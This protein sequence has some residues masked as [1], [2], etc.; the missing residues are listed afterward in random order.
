MITVP[1]FRLGTIFRFFF[2]YALG[3]S[4]TRDAIGAVAP[5][6]AVV[7]LIGLA[8]EIR[9]VWRW[10]PSSSPPRASF[11][12]AR[13]FAIFW[14]CVVG[15]AIFAYFAHAFLLAAVPWTREALG[16]DGSLVSAE[17][18]QTYVMCI[19]VVLCNSIERWRPKTQNISWGLERRSRWLILLAL[20]LT[21]IVL[22]N[23]TLTMFVT[24]WAVSG[25]EAAQ[26][27]KF[28]R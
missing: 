13:R 8:Q 22:L 6:I 16:Y 14:R 23:A 20:P 9:Q 17:L 18:P 21:A 15:L 28:H 26:P 11:T 7:M 24:H 27:A 5:T 3:L 19:L 25:I 4:L 1:K 12:F 2:C 10:T